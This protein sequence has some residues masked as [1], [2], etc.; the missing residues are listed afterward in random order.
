MEHEQQSTPEWGVCLWAIRQ[1]G[2]SFL[3]LPIFLSVLNSDAHA[4]I[5]LWQDGGEPRRS[6]VE[7]EVPAQGARSLAAGGPSRR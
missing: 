7:G 5:G 2:K 6:W 3:I 1:L 4:G